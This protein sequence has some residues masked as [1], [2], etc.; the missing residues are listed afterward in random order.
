MIEIVKSSL[1]LLCSLCVYSCIYKEDSFNQLE[2]ALCLAGENRIE[3]EKVLNRY[4]R[5]PGD[6]L[7]LRAAEFLIENMPG[8]SY[9]EGALLDDYL[10]YY[11]LLEEVFEN[12]QDPS[13]AVD[14]IRNMFGPFSMDFLYKRQD[15]QTV[16]S[17][18]LCNN[19]EWAFK[20]W[21]EQPWNRHLSFDDFCESILPYRVGN[22]TLPDW[23]EKYYEEYSHIMDVFKQTDTVDIY[24]PLAA[25]DFLAGYI[26]PNEHLHFT[27]LVPAPLPHIGPEAVRHRCGSC[28]D[29]SDFVVY[30]FRALGIPCSVDYMPILR[31]D[32]TG[33]S[34]VAI[35]DKHGELYYQEFLR[36]IKKVKG[37]ELWSN[38]KLKVFRTTFAENRTISAEIHKYEE[39]LV[40]M[41]KAPHFEDVTK[42]YASDYIEGLTI[43]SAEMYPGRKPDVVYLCASAG[44]S[45]IPMAWAP[46]KKGKAVFSNLDHGDILRVASV[47]DGK[48]RF[49]TDPFYIDDRKQL[50]FLDASGDIQQIVVFSKMPQALEDLHQT[51]MVGG[52]FEGSNDIGFHDMD[53]LF[54]V[55]E[56]PYRLI[57]NVKIPL[58]RPYRYVRYVGP[59]DSYCNVSEICFYDAS[60]KM[61]KCGRPIGTPGCSGAIGSHEFSNATDGKTW[62]SFDYKDAEGGWTGLDL[63][64]P[65]KI[66]G[67]SYS[68]RNYDN[69]VRPGDTYELF[70][71]DITW[72]SGGVKKAE[73]D[74]LIFNGIPSDALLLLKNHTRGVQTNVFTYEDK[75]QVWEHY[76]Y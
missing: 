43:A 10:T 52:V 12:R 8:H 38:N 58:S 1:I 6:S 71:C 68:P 36:E 18:Y 32:Y 44:A 75:E 4:A 33:H 55:K 11:A 30:A 60:G 49:W 59:Y 7:K 76:N 26:L 2:N 23:R 56:K 45:W 73:S 14:S 66:S 41:F 61:I 3:L 40:E 29:L 48:M 65:M 51:R 13:V 31:N 28:R 35:Y 62:T 47:H 21:T 42:E 22:E 9:Y 69:Y 5:N 50:N 54:V 15:I 19:I 27:T 46:F 34:W 25:A 16:D 37:S 72:K 53:T 20:V 74:S 17:A 64:T 39:C 70:W 63:G 67:I 24:D 57:T